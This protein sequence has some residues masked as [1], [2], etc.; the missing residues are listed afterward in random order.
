MTLETLQKEMMTALKEKD[1]LRKETIAAII[2]TAKMQA[3]ANCDKDNVS[4]ELVDAAIRKEHKTVNE[5]LETCPADRTDKK[6]EYTKRK[7][8]IESLMPKQ[9]TENE[10]KSILDDKFSEVLATKNKGEIMK[11]I[12]PF[13]KGK[14]DGKLVNG[15][16]MSYLK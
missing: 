4:E 12:M 16:I 13:F 5:Q 11:N 2:N 8:I 14:A 15:I 7:E 6:E 10:I 3:I 9:L 1:K